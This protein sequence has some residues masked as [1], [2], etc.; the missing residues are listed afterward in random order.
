M[1][2]VKLSMVLIRQPTV[3]VVLVITGSVNCSFHFSS[4]NGTCGKWIMRGHNQ[5]EVAGVLTNI[6][7]EVYRLNTANQLMHKNDL[8]TPH[9]FSIKVWRTPKFQLR[10][11]EYL[12]NDAVEA[13]SIKKLTKHVKSIHDVGFLYISGPTLKSKSATK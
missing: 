2:L 6:Y 5:H 12:H 9:L 8:E 10:A 1:Y 7:V 13:I 11:S 3:S 4:G